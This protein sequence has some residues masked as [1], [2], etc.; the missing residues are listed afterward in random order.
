VK[1]F[2]GLGELM[3]Q[4]A[5]SLSLLLMAV[6]SLAQVRE[7]PKL[8]LEAKSVG[9]NWNAFRDQ[10]QE[11]AKDFAKNC[12]DVQVTTSKASADYEIVLNHIEAGLLFRDNQLAITDMFG[13]LL[14]TKEGGSIAK[15]VRGACALILSNWSNRVGSKQKLLDAINGAFQ[16]DGILGY[17]ELS[18]EKLTVHSQ[19]A[20]EMRFHMT[21]V[22]GRMLDMMRRAGVSTYTYTND[23]DQ[24]FLYDVRAAQI[25][26]FTAAPVV[27][28]SEPP[29]RQP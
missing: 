15:G 5:L 7:T 8:Y 21:L 1:S 24:N 3:K 25:I 18:G 17:A 19:R 6:G 13:N 16:R 11:M 14:S 4:L 27:S 10:S 29:A 28:A 9:S 22:S 26:P 2:L 23:S 12:P 20:T